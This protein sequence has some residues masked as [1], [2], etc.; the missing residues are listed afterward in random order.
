M[1]ASRSHPML[2][3]AVLLL[4]GT[5][6]RAEEVAPGLKVG[7]VLDQHNAQLAKDLLPPEILKHYETGDYRNRIVSYPTGTAHYEK[8]FLDE[9]E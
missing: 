6:A 5:V 3:A 4:L 7:D 2:V 8:S 1:K 9:T